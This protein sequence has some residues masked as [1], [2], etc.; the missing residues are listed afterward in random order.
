MKYNYLRVQLA[1]LAVGPGI[2]SSFASDGK[3][4]NKRPNIIFIMSDDHSYQAISAY[5]HP[6]SRVAPTPHIDRIAQSGMVF[7]KAFVE[8]SIS[9]PS[10]ATLLTGMY[11]EH[12]GQ[13]HFGFGLDT[14]KTFFSECLQQ[15]GYQTSVFGKWHVNAEPKGFDY[16]DILYDQGDYYNPEFRTPKTNGKY[17]RE[18]GY[19]TTLITD[20]AIKW[21]DEATQD[22]EKPFCMV[23]LHK[24]PHRNWMPDLKHL[25]TFEDKAF[26]EPSNLFDDY[27]TRG[28]QMQTQELTIAKHL[29]YAFDLKVEQL[30]DEPT[31]EYIKNSWSLA[32][33]RLDSEQR[34]EWDKAYNAIH[35]DFLANRP[36][37]KELISWKYQRYIKDYCKTVQS[38]DEQV[39]RV[40]DYLKEHGLEEN[41]I[42]VYTSDQ[43]F[44]MGEHGLYDKRFMYEESFRTPFIISYPREI[45]KGT[46]CDKL[47]QN[48]DF[49]PTMLDLAGV[50]IPKE[51]DG[52]S[53]RSLFHN[54]KS[55]KWRKELY[56]HF[57]DYPAV[58]LVRQHYGIRNER[59]KLIHWYGKGVGQDA[60][61][62]LDNWELYDL[63][64]DPTE[65]NNIYNNKNHENVKKE[66][67][68]KLEKIMKHMK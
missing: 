23:L 59:Y 28:S 30:K 66:L 19:A 2:V 58:G 57:F 47:I 68:Q 61:I 14:T 34:S 56:Y 51:M 26:P 60:G 7:D 64:K 31:L 38:V 27:D 44:L 10:R 9:T 17:I 37:G 42:I 20:H 8:N 65:M 67:H 32:M 13:T 54:P 53:L 25:Y 29:G 55:S 22:T 36:E 50:E 16:Y 49:A 48:I 46:R 24:A 43:G 3:T 5:G 6:I 63:E 62:D 35:K 21:L 33:D 40:L 45:K 12:H 15:A 41:T 1:L 52:T 18:R 39:G 4:E 11:S